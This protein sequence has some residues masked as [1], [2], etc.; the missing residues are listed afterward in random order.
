MVFNRVERPLI[1]LFANKH[2]AQLPT[3]CSWGPDP[4]AIAQDAMTMSWDGT[5]A[6]AFPPIALIPRV[7]EKLDQV[8]ELS[9]PPDRTKLAS[10]DMVS[11]ASVHDDSGSSG[12]SPPAGSDH[13][14]RQ[15]TASLGDIENAEADSMAPYIRAYT[16]AGL[17]KSAAA[18]AGNIENGAELTK[19]TL[20][21]PL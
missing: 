20:T 5:S 2:N 13:E 17:S 18:T 9:S 3:Y 14:G 15:D 8:I 6:Y 7:L 11:H 4:A 10:S 12:T 19:W 16:A 1:D 21:K